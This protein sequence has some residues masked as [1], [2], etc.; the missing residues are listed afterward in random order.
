MIES[1]AGR[2]L[3]GRGLPDNEFSNIIDGQDST[4][5]L[6][7][8]NYHYHLFNTIYNIIQIVTANYMQCDIVVLT[9]LWAII[10]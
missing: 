8:L 6:N 1:I 2:Q 3:A 10:G 7:Q 5:P 9:H 4:L